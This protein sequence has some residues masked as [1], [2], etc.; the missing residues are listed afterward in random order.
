MT[1]IWHLAEPAEWA[2]A[3]AAGSYRGSTRGTSL[4]QVGYV[5]CSSPQQLPA[6]VAAV[7]ADMT[8]DLVVLELDRDLLKAAG[9]PVR[10]GPETQAIPA[11]SPTRTCTGQCRCP[12]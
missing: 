9:S 12:L 3:Q 1:T 11:R 2:A 8:A 10:D 5:H 6:V 4:E 7:Y